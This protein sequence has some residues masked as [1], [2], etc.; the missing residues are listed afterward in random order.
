MPRTTVTTAVHRE[1]AICS[2][3]KTA[4]DRVQVGARTL[5]RPV[6]LLVAAGPDRAPRKRGDR[7][8]GKSHLSP[9]CRGHRVVAR[10][11]ASPGYHARQA[12]TGARPPEKRPL[13]TF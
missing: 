7:A 3:T 9:P 5:N 6:L 4:A 11:R 1:V 10:Q 2:C 13:P 12:R 8:E